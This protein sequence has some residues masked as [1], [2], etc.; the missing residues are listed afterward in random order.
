MC[1]DALVLLISCLTF[2]LKLI[3][4]QPSWVFSLFINLSQF[5]LTASDLIQIVSSMLDWVRVRVSCFPT[6]GW[7][8]WGALDSDIFIAWVGLGLALT[9]QPQPICT[10]SLLFLMRAIFYCILDWLKR[11]FT[12]IVI[13]SWFDNL[14]AFGLSWST[15]LTKIYASQETW[16]LACHG[17]ICET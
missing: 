16:N 3:L 9:T 8:D 4:L 17:I 11:H 14:T 7:A 13:S 6:R 15:K 10:L 12:I 2:S 5:N 1:I